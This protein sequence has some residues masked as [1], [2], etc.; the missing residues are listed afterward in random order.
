MKYAAGGSGYVTKIS[1]LGR[2]FSN[3]QIESFTKKREEQNTS[4]GNWF[5]G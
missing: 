4:D 1:F 3:K 2:I 5:N